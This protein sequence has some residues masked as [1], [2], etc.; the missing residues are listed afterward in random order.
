MGEFRVGGLFFCCPEQQK[1]EQGQNRD[2]EH[3]TTLFLMTEIQGAGGSSQ[4]GVP[5]DPHNLACK[6]CPCLSARDPSNPI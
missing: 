1:L 4:Q 6:L 3:T 2:T 5:G